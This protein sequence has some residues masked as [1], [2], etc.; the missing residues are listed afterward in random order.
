MNYSNWISSAISSSINPRSDGQSNQDD[1]LIKEPYTG[2]VFPDSLVDNDRGNSGE[3]T[4]TTKSK[5]QLFVG[6]G[7]RVAYSVVSVY[8]VGTYMDLD[9]IQTLKTPKSTTSTNEKSTTESIQKQLLD[10]ANP[11]TIKI[12]MARS[13]PIKQYMDAITEALTSRMDGRDLHTLE[14]LDKLNP[15]VDLAEGTEMEMRICKTDD[16]G[17]GCVMEYKSSLGGKGRIE[18]TTFCR[19][20]CDVYYG[21]DP[22]SVDHRDNVLKKILDE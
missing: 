1:D 13:V 12:V 3:G 19:A 18:S 15:P 9:I 21:H 8:A 16:G 5:Q 10:P 22:V 4:T 20:L 6:C 2:I 14:E 17:D 11:R 7:V